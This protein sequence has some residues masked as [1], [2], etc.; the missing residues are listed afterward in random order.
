MTY[1]QKG[2]RKA[3]SI[4]MKFIIPKLALLK[5]SLES[6]Q[7][8]EQANSEN[9]KKTYLKIYCW[10]GGIRSKS[11]VWLANKFGL[12]AIRLEGGYKSYRKWVLEQFEK[13]WGI[14][15]IGG[16]TGTGKTKLL[17]SLAKEGIS[18]I[19]L[20]GLANHRGSSYGAMGLKIQPSCEHYEN[21]IA[22]SLNK[23]NKGL[24][25]SIWLEDESPNLGRCRI[26]NGLINQMKVAP[27]IEILKS[28]EE[29]LEELIR[30][31]SQNTQEELEAATLRITKRLGPQRTK[32]A[33]EAIR[34]KDWE[35][36]CKEILD[37]YDRC[38]EHQLKKITHKK[39]I[40]LS[41]MNNEDAARKLIKEGLIV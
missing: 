3:I 21:L 26:P 31:Y 35:I 32:I 29:R 9:F 14:H 30:V 6:L 40:D 5:N 41:G 16:K 39:T 38:Y 7:E 4:G 25:T 36:A 15:L 33:I 37:Y 24:S 17:N 18:T 12:N 13:E 34:K 20:E 11:F 19:D 28:K 8:K 10:R 23:F 22:N 1:K 2:S 27:V